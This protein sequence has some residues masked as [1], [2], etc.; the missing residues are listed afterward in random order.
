MAMVD[1][2]YL[3]RRANG[4]LLHEQLLAAGIVTAGVSVGPR[5]IVVHV[6][7]TSALEVVNAVVEAHDA[8]QFTARQL[9]LEQLDFAVAE[10]R[11]ENLILLGDAATLADV[12]KKLQWLELELRRLLTI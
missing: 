12:R 1:I 5:G 4:E 8:K 3:G 2:E 6:D 10:K 11:S 9:A 7:E